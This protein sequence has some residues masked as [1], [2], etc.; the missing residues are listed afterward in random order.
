M[1]RCNRFVKQEIGDSMESRRRTA[2]KAVIWNIMGLAMMAVVGLVATGSAAV[3]GT[4]ALVNTAI[5]L[6]MYL[7]YERVWAGIRWGRHV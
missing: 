5:G 2:L 3:G 4:M 7:L 1:V 6:F